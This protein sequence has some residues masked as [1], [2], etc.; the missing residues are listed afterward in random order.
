LQRYRW[1]PHDL[2]SRRR[3]RRP[4]RK[5]TQ[6][7]AGSATPCEHSST[8]STPGCGRATRRGN[9]PGSGAAGARSRSA[10]TWNAAAPPSGAEPAA[11]APPA[12][13]ATTLVGSVW[14]AEDIGGA[15]VIDNAQSKLQFVSAT[16]VAGSGACNSFTGAATVTATALTLGPLASTRK[17]CAPAVMDQ[18]SRFLRALE[19]VKSARMDGDLLLLMDAAGSPL[20]RLSR[21]Q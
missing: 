4:K 7:R 6:A 8:A 19:A 21:Q 9:P 11:T 12:F 15:G 1:R 14:L 20:A 13:E 5:P 18:E 3:R 16:Q 10:C 2:K 17:M